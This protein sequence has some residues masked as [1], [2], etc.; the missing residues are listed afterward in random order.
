V[1][2]E[3]AA[4]QAE[5]LNWN[6]HAFLGL[7]T[8]LLSMAFAGAGGMIARLVMGLDVPAFQT[9]AMVTSNQPSVP[10]VA[11]TT[12][13]GSI[14]RDYQI[15]F[16]ALL[17]FT[18]VIVTLL[19]NAWLAR[20]QHAREIAA[21]R[22]SVRGALLAE[23]RVLRDSY[24]ERIDRMQAAEP[25]QGII[26][27][28]RVHVDVYDSLRGKLGLLTPNEAER[29]VLTYPFVGELPDQVRQFKRGQRL[30]VDQDTEHFIMVPHEA[31]EHVLEM[32]RARLVRINEAITALTD[33]SRAGG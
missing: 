3:P 12:A 15:A 30:P 18:G 27:P 17:G 5:K 22:A 10:L 1:A 25:G 19:V 29:A 9:A 28:T 24:Q 26:A 11:A 2:T 7:L 6:S 23:L 13:S 14:L 4:I 8:G 33:A 16:G 31:I 21:E 20:R 32:H